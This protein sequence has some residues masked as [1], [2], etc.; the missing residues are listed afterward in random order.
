MEVLEDR[1]MFDGVPDGTLDPAALSHDDP[2]IDVADSRVDGERD[3]ASLQ[4]EPKGIVFVD[5]RVAGFERL[6]AN[7]ATD[8]NRE[9]VFLNKQI[10]TLS[11]I[12][13]VLADRNADDG[14]VYDTVQTV[15]AGNAD[16]PD[17]RL[18]TLDQASLLAAQTA[19]HLEGFDESSSVG[20]AAATVAAVRTEV[21]VIDSG[22]EDAETILAGLRDASDQVTDWIVVRIDPS[23]DGIQQISA[24]LAGQKSVDA[25]HLISHGDGRGIDLGGTHLDID[26]IAAFA[27]EVALWGNAFAEDA[28]ILI[29]GC[30][31]ASTEAGRS[32]VEAMAALTDADVA[33]SDDATGHE[34]LGGDWELEFETGLIGT[35]SLGQTWSFDVSWYGTLATINGTSGSDILEGTNSTDTISGKGGNDILLGGVDLIDEGNFNSSSTSTQL[36]VTTANSGWDVSSGSVDFLSASSGISLPNDPNDASLRAVDLNDGEISRLVG[37]LTIG[38]TY[39]VAFFMGA[40]GVM[41]QTLDVAAVGVDSASMSVTMPS[42]NNLSNIDWQVKL[43]TFT[44]TATSHSIQFTSTSGSPTAGAIIAGVRLVHDNAADGNDTIYGNAGDDL[45]IGGGGDNELWEDSGTNIIVS[46][47]GEDDIEGGDDNDTIYAGDG[48]NY[49]DGGSGDDIIMSG[50]GDDELY[51]GGDNDTID[52]GDGENI[53]VGDA[54][55]DNI[56]AGSGD[57]YIR[58]GDGNDVIDGGDGNNVIDGDTGN[59]Q[60]TSGS[61]NDEIWSTEGAD[62]IFAGAGDDEIYSYGDMAQDTIDGGEGADTYYIYVDDTADVFQDSGTDGAIDILYLYSGGSETYYIT[63]QF[64]KA[65]TGIDTIYNDWTGSTSYLGSSSHATALYWDFSGMELEAVEQVH[66]GTQNDTIILDS[67]GPDNPNAIYG[68]GGNDTLTDGAGVHSLYGGPGNDRLYGG[69]GNDR[70]FG[71]LGVDSARYDGAL[72]DYTINRDSYGLANDASVLR[73]HETTINGTDEENDF[74]YGTV[75]YLYFSD[76]TYDTATGGFVPNVLQVHSMPG[77]QEIAV[78]AGLTF[79]AANGNSISITDDSSDLLEVTLSVSEGTVTLGAIPAGLSFSSND[80]TNDATMTFTGTV[81]DINTALDG[82]QFTSPVDYE[83]GAVLS[84]ESSDLNFGTSDADSLL[85]KIGDALVVDTA[86]D[87]SNNGDTSSLEALYL[88]K[89]SDGLISLREAIIASNN[90]L[91]TQAIRF[92]ISGAGPH[93]IA[94]TSALPLISDGVFID[95]WSEPDYAADGVPVIVIDAGGV[96]SFDTGLE[97]SLG[98]DGSTVRGLVLSNISHHGIEIDSDNNWIYGNYI[99]VDASGLTAAAVG[100]AGVF[101]NAGASNNIIGTNGDAVADVSER[102]VIGAGRNGVFLAGDGVNSNTIAGNYIGVGVDGETVLGLEFHGVRI[103]GD[104]SNNTIGGATAALGNVIAGADDAAVEIGSESTTNSVLNNRIGISADGNTLL[105]D[106][107][108]GVSILNGADGTT[109]IGNSIGGS[110]QAGILIDGDSVG[111]VI[112]GNTIGTDATGTLNWGNGEQGILLAGGATGTVIGGVGA[113]EGNT[114]AF[115]GQADPDNGAGI[116]IWGTATG[117]TIQ[118]NSIYSNQG[119]GIDLGVASDDGADP[120]DAGDS[121]TGG[122]NKQNWGEAGGPSINDAGDFRYYVNLYSFAGGTTYTLDFYASSDRDGGQ[123]EGERYLFSRTGLTNLQSGWITETGIDAT[124]GEYITVTLTDDTTGDTSEFSSY[125]VVVDSDGS[126]SAPHDLTLV[127]AGDGGVEINADGGKDANLVVHSDGNTGSIGDRIGGL[128]SMT[129]EVDFAAA[130]G[131]HQTLLS[132]AASDPDDFTLQIDPDAGNGSVTVMINGSANQVV[133]SGI[134]Y[135]TL[136]DGHRHQLAF[137]WDNTDGDWSIYVDGQLAESGTGLAT[138]LTLAGDA[139]NGTLMFGQEQDAIGG[140]FNAFDTFRGTYFDAR[141][142]DSVRSAGQIAAGA[143]QTLAY[144]EPGMLANWTFNDLST[145]GVVTESVAGNSLKLEAAAASGFTS[146]ESVLSVWLDENAVNGTSVGKVYGTDIERE[147]L[148]AAFLA[149][150]PT[151]HYSEETDKFYKVLSGAYDRDAADAAA[152]GETLNANAGS[153]LTIESAHEN[154]LVRRWI[155]ETG[156]SRVWLSGSDLA[157]AD[158]WRW[159]D[160][161]L[162]FDDDGA[163]DGAYENFASGEPDGAVDPSIVYLSM[164]SDGQ[165]ADSAAAQ[166]STGVI[167]EWSADEA[168]DRSRMVLYSIQSQTTPG[169]FAIDSDSGVITVADASAIDYETLDSHQLNIRVSDNSGQ[170]YKELFTIQ[171]LDGREPVSLSGLEIGTLTYTENDPE[172]AITSTLEATAPEVVA[173]ESATIAISVGYANGQDVLTFDTTN[174]ITGDWDAATGTLTLTGS[175]T[176]AAYQTALRSVM[177]VNTSEVPDE[178][179]REV[180]FTV[181]DGELDSNTVHRS[182]AVASVNDAPTFPLGTG[183]LTMPDDAYQGSE[184]TAIL[185]QPDGKSLVVSPVFRPFDDS[186]GLNRYTESGVLD[187]SFGGGDGSVV[188]S[189]GTGYAYPTSASLQADGKIVVAGSFYDI[190]AGYSVA[191][192]ARYNIDGTLDTSFGTAG[193][194]TTVVAG[195]SSNITEVTVLADGKILGAGY[196]YDYDGLNEIALFQFNSDGTLDASFGAGNGYVTATGLADRSLANSMVVQSDGKILVAGIIGNGG[197]SDF[198]VARY[199]SDGTL[200]TSFDGDGVVNIVTGGTEAYVNELLLQPD[201]KILLVG[202]T[203]VNGDSDSVVVRLLADGSIDTSFGGGDGMGITAIAGSHETIYAAAIQ[204]DGKIVGVGGDY[205]PATFKNRGFT[206]RYNSDGTLDTSFGDDGIVPFTLGDTSSDASYGIAFDDDGKVL[207]AGSSYSTRGT[208]Y[209]VRYNTDGTLDMTY[210]A[211]HQLDGA[212]IFIENGSAVVLDDDVAIVDADLIEL[213]NFAGATLTLQRNVAAND[214]DL[215]S[216]TGTLSFAG[217]DLVVD[218]T[219]IGSVTNT[220]GTLLL[221]FNSNATHALVRAAMSQIAYANANDT[222]AASVQI[223]WM[224]DDGNTGDQGS[225]GALSTVGSTTVA[226]IA[227]NDAPVVSGIET[228]AIDYTENDGAVAISSTLAISDGD[229]TQIESA[230]VAISSGYAN[231][232]DLLGFVDQNGIMGAWD[233]GTGTLTLSGSAT[234]AEYQTALRSVTYTNSSESPNTATRTVSVTVNDGDENSATQNRDIAITAVNDRP[235]YGSIVLPTFT[236]HELTNNALGASFVTTADMDGDGDLDVLSASFV[237]DRII[238]FENDGS[239]IFTE[240]TVTS[241]ADGSLAVYVVDLDEDG[242]LDIVSASHLDDTV[243]WYENDGNENFT[244]HVI[245]TSA[246]FAASVTAADVDGDGDLDILSASYRDHKIVWYENDGN[247]NFTIR[248]ITSTAMG[249]RSVATADMDGD[250][251]LD[252]LSAARD[253]STVIW[254]ENDGSENFTTHVIAADAEGAMHVMTADVDGDGDLDVLSASYDDNSVT[255]Y[256]NDGSQNFTQHVVDTTAVGVISVAAADVDGDGDLDLLSASSVG[257]T[258]AWYENDGNQNFTQ[259]MIAVASDGAR[260]VIMADIDGDGDLDVVTASQYDNTVTWYESEVIALIGD[261]PTFVEDGPAVVL[262]SG[263][264]IEDMELTSL[265]DFDGASLSFARMGGPSPDDHF[266]ATG[267]LAFVGTTT[268]NIELSSVVIGTYTNTAGTLTLSFA[269]GTTNAQVNAAARAIAYSNSNNTPPTSVQ[270]DWTFDDGNT[271]SQGIGGAR[272]AI[273]RTTVTI[274]ATNDDPTNAGSLPSSISVIEDVSSNVDLSLIDLSDFDAGTS[275]LTVSLTT[276]TGGH[277]T[278]AAAAGITVGGTSTARTLTG[279]L[280]D[281]NSYLNTASNLTYLHGTADINGDAADTIQVDVTDNG[282]TGNGGGGTIDLG[283]VDVDIT[284]VNDDPTNAGSLPATITVTED[285]LSNVDLSAIDL[286]DVDHNGGDLTL[287]LT[288]STGGNLTAS[289]LGGVWIAGSGSSSLSLTGTLSMLNVYLNNASAIQYLSG[290]SHA[291]GIAADTLQL[292]FTDNGHSGIGGGLLIDFG[293]LD[294]DIASVND[295]PTFEIGDGVVTT[296]VGALNESASD[297]L[298]QPDGKIVVAGYVHNGLSFDFGLVRYNV[299]GTLDTSFGGGD[300]VVTTATGSQADIAYS[301][302]LQP[303]GKILL[304]GFTTVSGTYHHTVVRY[305]ID[306]TLDSSFG[307]GGIVVSN[308]GANGDAG[309]SVTLQSDGKI[310]VSGWKMSGG[311]TGSMLVRYHSDGTLDTS[312]GGGDGIVVSDFGAT[313][314]VYDDVVVQADGK[315]LVAG[316]LD[317][318]TAT[319]RDISLVRYNSDGTLD[320]SFG[321]AGIVST[322]LGDSTDNASRIVLTAD[323][324]ILLSGYSKHAGDFDFTVLRYNSDGTLDFSFGGGLGVVTTDVQAD[325]NYANGLIMQDDGKFLVAGH[326]ASGPEFVVVRYHSDGTLDTSFGDDGIAVGAVN[327]GIVG[328]NNATLQADGKILLTGYHTQSANS[329]FLLVRYNSD[330]TLDTRFGIDSSSLAGTVSYTEDGPAVVLDINVELSDQELDAL[331]G[332]DGNYAGAQITLVRDGGAASEDVLDFANGNGITLVGDQLIKNGQSIATFDTTTTAGALVITFTDGNGEIPT[333]SDVVQMLRQL[334]YANSNDTPPASVQIHWTFNDG[335]TGSQGSGGALDTTGSTLVTITAVDDAPVIA[336]IESIAIDYIENDGAVAISPSLTI[337][338]VDDTHIVSAVVAIGAG[339]ANGQDELSFVNQNGIS[340]NWNASTGTLVLSGTATLAQYQTTLR[341]VTYANSSEVPD[342]TTRTI[343]FT[344]HDGQSNSNVVAR[345]ITITSVN[346]GPVFFEPTLDSA[347]LSFVHVELDGYN[348]IYLESIVLQSDGKSLLLGTAA[349]GGVYELALVRYTASGISDTSFG[350][351]DGSTVTSFGSDSVYAASVALQADGKILVA[352]N[353]YHDDSSSIMLVRYNSDGTLDSSFG[354]GDGITTT[355]VS[356]SYDYVEEIT[357]QDD[358]KILVVGRITNGAN[359][360]FGAIRYNSDGSLDASFGGG[361]GIVED[362]LGGTV[363]N[364][365][366]IIVQSDGKILIAGGSSAGLEY[367]VVVARLNSD[368]SWDSGFDGDGILKFDLGGIDSSASSVVLQSD[369]RIVVAGYISTS[370]NSDSDSFVVRLLAD[371]T[372]DTSFSDDGIVITDVDGAD[373]YVG[374]ATVQGDGKIVVLSTSYGSTTHGQIIRYNVD[375]TIDSS[376]GDDGVVNIA[377]GE[378]SEDYS[379]HLVIDADGKM[380][381]VGNSYSDDVIGFVQRLNSDGTLD[382]T[383]GVEDPLAG[384]PS[385]VEGGAAFVL[386]D[387]VSIFDEELVVDDNFADSTLTLLRSGGANA[388]DQFIATGTLSFSGG[389]LV[390]NGITIGSVTNDAGTLAMVFNGNVTQALLSSAMQQIAYAN[391]SDTPP[392][393]VQI[394]WTFDDGNTGAQGIVGALTA[395]QS[396]I[397]AITAVNDEQVLAVNTGATVVEG[398][399]AN[400]ITS[401]M[402]QTTDVDNTN[403][404]LVYVVDTLPSNGTL[405]RDSVAMSASDTFSQ[406][407][408]AAGLITYDHD[409]SQTTSDSFAFTVDDGAGTTSSSSFH[410]TIT[411]VNDAPYDLT[412]TPLSVAENSAN[413]TSVGT[414]TGYDVDSASLTYSIFAQDFPGAFAIDSVTGEITVAD[415]RLLN[416]ED[417]TSQGVTVR[418]TDASGATYDEEMTVTITDEAGDVVATADAITVVAGAPIVIDPRGND[419][420]GSGD[421]LVVT[422]IIDA[423]AGDAVTQLSSPGDTATLASGTTLTLR[424]DGRLTVVAAADGIET[425]AYRVSD[426]TTDDLELVTLT[427]D[428]NELAAQSIGLVTTWDTTQAGSASDTITIAAAPGS[429]NYTV[430]WGDGTSTVGASGDLSHTY[431]SPGQYTVTIVGDFAGFNFDGGGDAAKILSVEQWGNVAFEDLDDAFDGAVNLQINAADA[432]DL[433]GV[434]SLKEMFNGAT[435]MNADLSGW[436]VASVDN[437][438]G[439]FRGAGSFNQDLSGWDVSNVTNMASMFYGASSFNEDVSSWDVSSVTSMVGMFQDAGSFNQDVNGWDVSNVTSMVR[440][441]Y[442]AGT[443]NQDVSGWDVS[444]VTSMINMFYSASSFNQDINDWD[445]SNVTSTAIMFYGASSFNG[446]VSGWDVSSV[447]NMVGMFQDAVSFDQDVSGWDVSNVTN[448]GRMFSGA[449]SFNQDISGWDVSNVTSMINM[450]YNAGSFNQDVSRWDVSNVTGM[451]S[452]FSGASSFNQD[453]SGWDVSNVTGMASMFSGAGSFNQD[454]SEW[455][456]SGVTSMESMFQD[457]SAF[458]QNLG[459]WD[460]SSL[461]V[462]TSMLSNSDLSIPNYDATL[463]GWASQTVKP[464]VPLGADGLQYSI[465]AQAARDLLINDHNWSITGDSFYNYVPEITSDGGADTASVHV[466]EDTA[467]VTTVAASDQDGLLNTLSYSIYGGSDAARFAIDS[468]TGELAFLS[469][470]D[471]ENPTDVGGDNL[472]N[473]V[474]RVSDDQGGTDDQTLTV[475]VSSINDAPLA[476]NDPSFVTD[477]ATA[478]TGLDILANDIDVDVDL[479]TISRID[480]NAFTVGVPISLASGTLV[481]VNPDGT[482]DFDPANVYTQLGDIHSAI[483][484]FTYEIADGQGAFDTATVTIQIQG[485]DNPISI[486]ELTDGPTIDTD[487]EVFESDLPQ[488]T[489]AVGVGESTS[490]TF[491]LQ[492]GDGLVSL[493][494]D[495]RVITA[496][497]LID[498]AT[499]PVFVNTSLGRLEVSGY[500]AISGVVSYSYTLT[501]SGDH[502]AGSVIDNIALTITDTDG[503][504]VNATLGILIHDDLPSTSDDANSVLEDNGTAATGNVLGN[505]QV[506]ADQTAKLVA[507]VGSGANLPSAIHLGQAL[508]GTYGTIAMQADGSYSYL[509]D[510]LD[511]AVS[512]LSTGESLTDQF[513]YEVVDADGS[514]STATLTIQINGTNDSPNLSSDS[515]ATFESTAT[516]FDLLANDSDDEGHALSITQIDGQPILVGGQVAVAGGSVTL[517]ADGTV[518]FVPTAGFS[519]SFAFEYAVEDAL[520]GSETAAVQV[521]VVPSDSRP[522]VTLD[523]TPLTINDPFD[524]PTPLVDLPLAQWTHDSGTVAPDLQDP[525]LVAAAANE[526][527]HGGLNIAIGGGSASIQ[528]VDAAT[529]ANAIADEDY[530]AYS[531]TV[532]DPLPQDHHLLLTG[533]EMF[534]PTGGPDYLRTVVVSRDPDFATAT[535]IVANDLVSGDGVAIDRDLATAISVVAGETLYFR[536][537]LYDSSGGDVVQYDNFQAKFTVLDANDSVAFSEGDPAVAVDAGG[538]ADASD[539]GDADLVQ[540][541]INLSGIVDANA[542]WV[543]IAGQTVDLSSSGNWTGLGVGGSVVDLGYNQ[544]TQSFTITNYSGAGDAIPQ[545]D[546]DLLIRGLQYENTSQNPSYG[547]RTFEFVLTDAS[548]LASAPVMSN[549]LVASVNDLPIAVNDSFAIDQDTPL[550]GHLLADNG[551]GVD[552]DPD[553]DTLTVTQINGQAFASGH[554]FALPS[555]ATIQMFS[556]GTFRFDPGTAFDHLGSGEQVTDSFSYQ[557]SDFHGGFATATVTIQIDG[558]DDPLSID[559]IDDGI[560]SGTDA[561][562]DESHLATGSAAMPGGATTSGSFVLQVGDQIESLQVAGVSITTAQLLNA[563]TVPVVIATTHGQ[564]TIDSYDSTSGQVD[565]RYELTSA[566]DHSGGTATESIGLIARDLDGDQT[567][568]TLVI[569]IVDDL[570]IANDDWDEV[571]NVAGNPSSVADGNVVTGQGSGSDP[572]FSDGVV[573]RVGADQVSAPVTGV[574]AGTGSPDNTSGNLGLP[575][576]GAFGS[577]V[578][579]ADGAYMYTPD[580]A[581]A[582]VAALGPDESLTDVFTYQITDADGSQ[583]TATITFTILGTP[584]IIGTQD[585]GLVTG[586]DASVKEADL[587]TGSTA[588]PAGAT[589]SGSFLVIAPRGL[590]QLK[591]AGTAISANQLDWVGGAPIMV[592]TPHGSIQILSYDQAT[593]LVEYKFTL[594]SPIDHANG[595]GSESITLAVKDTFGDEVQK[596]MLIAIVDDAPVAHDDLEYDNG[597]PGV[598][599]TGNVT[600]NDIYGANGPAAD[601]IRSV[602]VGSSDPNGFEHQVGSPINGL[603]GWLTLSADG[604]FAYQADPARSAFQ[605][606]GD[607]QTANDLFTYQIADADGSTSNAELIVVVSGLNEAPTAEGTIEP[608]TAY[609]GQTIVPLDIRGYFGD[610][611]ATDVLTYADNG[612]LPTGLSLDSATGIISGTPSGDASQTG[613]YAVQITA[614]DAE[615]LTATQSFTW[616]VHNVAPVA[617]EHTGTV[618]ESNVYIGQLLVGNGSD[619]DPDGDTPLQVVAVNGDPAAVGIAVTLQSGAIVQIHADGSYQYDPNGQFDNL[620]VGQSAL[621]QFAYTISDG[622]GGTDTGQV[623]VTIHGENEPP[624]VGD[625]QIKVGANVSTV[626]PVLQNAY[627]PNGDPLTVIVL[628]QPDNASVAVHPNGTLTFTPNANFVGETSFRYLVEDPYG[629]TASATLEVEV[630]APFAFDSLNDFSKGFGQRDRVSVGTGSEDRSPLSMQIFALAAEPIVSGHANYGSQIVG[631]IYDSSGRLIGERTTVADIGGNW[632]MQFQGVSNFEHYRIEIEQ[633]DASGTAIPGFGL[634]HSNSTYQTLQPLTHVRETLTVERV[635]REMPSKAIQ[636]GHGTLNNPLGLGI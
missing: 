451:A 207:V 379:S 368:G 575:V 367:S 144:S 364:I 620:G 173:I 316:Y 128:G 524:G 276:S 164:G 544:Y 261:N 54:G 430:Y 328:I 455:D 12:A 227:V 194:V 182:I 80:G 437:M 611:D 27:G 104:A 529:L 118:G 550:D 7:L 630:R 413:G 148:I 292:S 632:T 347:D 635:M 282:N 45:I 464:N 454:V 562:V 606:L 610:R 573:D 408:I 170:N 82:L 50:S 520:G 470:P 343:S 588:D 264:E 291:N 633:N 26:S 200:D 346:D 399:T 222:P 245:T 305:N 616:N 407:D 63:D 174:G 153:L 542:E 356:G 547:Q 533:I 279:N 563:Q 469:A 622:Q 98:S 459:D 168:L 256:E 536:V 260:S 410:W 67:A 404:E 418:V 155:S 594:T 199:N 480:G 600:D 545:S 554:V 139:A 570:A 22:V 61:G 433:S 397:V 250:G 465:A 514:R 636:Q 36:D 275:S 156:E 137:T 442:G 272:Q 193:M 149:A 44:A 230:T 378:D 352:A 540:L 531:V 220:G 302:T 30:D 624:Q 384:S 35:A 450:F 280:A 592:A 246:D 184:T 58:G 395:T 460:I 65:E 192:L 509:L 424:S 507:T 578:L 285:V 597:S 52:A 516:R 31:L 350:G 586:T 108:F 438:N 615:G 337:S 493:Q 113:G 32:L 359:N 198:A 111:S 522:E 360:D 571:I 541:S 76:G 322:D 180:R 163:V 109:I 627:D 311:T 49:V 587:S 73:V 125:S 217:G 273:G 293:T 584:T 101:L 298:E 25:L 235:T 295:A 312:F 417:A 48:N 535:T 385:Y 473:V 42:G 528:G 546:L 117:N 10:D 40:D 68:N 140:G 581:N 262:G 310:L 484:S 344:I 116:A 190:D 467:A 318:G 195:F 422:E 490:G 363:S 421:P 585:E 29:Y 221:A 89:G 492:P 28:D 393:S 549:I 489:D 576:A 47:A 553:G 572:N 505:D 400:T 294:V 564:L 102:N 115:S 391:A 240:H 110:V 376:F 237:D 500:N 107:T 41:T 33:A 521:A 411:P 466:N 440:M 131:A 201:G 69:A 143:G 175:A 383:Y 90:T 543:T 214:D 551:G 340:G 628:T 357:L 219:T 145:D 619:Y 530:L 191:A 141:V 18:V 133:A 614:T 13:D 355:N 268:G 8:A 612:S 511:P 335:N 99:G 66:G 151:L 479:L 381:V 255:W 604:G 46:G 206:V 176:L 263:V 513:T 446:N 401:A 21:V 134:D 57:D 568:V 84:M 333:S 244:L 51:G 601:P 1:V 239:G 607:G 229:G 608:Q 374:S 234:I 488:G 434:T 15:A 236:A 382:S 403:E 4:A 142:F 582:Q 323:G 197:D 209:L 185:L 179:T 503:D 375:G 138:G 218:G 23:D 380:I 203:D 225:G 72:A 498:T 339:Y 92:D 79:N 186:F 566:A 314:S 387:H 487:G 62:T 370:G 303:D 91:G 468:V 129:I 38:E 254:Y 277:L 537:Y 552:S 259:H 106:N 278:A 495:S 326:V 617:V 621:D 9:I 88:D 171:L 196:V 205:D 486:S 405:Y 392:A 471:Y 508:S 523:Q 83:G 119:I 429:S 428:S 394:D 159:D 308:I 613:P 398:A 317:S 595:Q 475:A 160:G 265:D 603:F 313:S 515:F 345:D 242:D 43:F 449:S 81:A 20:N 59:D 208:G 85:I 539:G 224:F 436:D 557:I 526:T 444:S 165:W 97:L 248:V 77:T 366:S 353:Q 53:V 127:A 409:D 253:D 238:W 78:A 443:F 301:A 625:S 286:S 478:L 123:V 331:N 112:Q 431:A 386:D 402:L 485:L 178:T 228:E 189:F 412:S 188:T 618:H 166:A 319:K 6:V 5:K 517:H 289:T 270:I 461:A 579:Q 2:L 457:A 499:T 358:G 580:Y 39:H 114:I 154:E 441:F 456:V 458:N 502:A 634:K 223:D 512:A 34:S 274:T 518:T 577:L 181:N 631:R 158:Q 169:A 297:I 233:V 494:I 147:A 152:S 105:G 532:A 569:Y 432:P 16:D 162:F 306:G 204:A 177:Y 482:I 599:L 623:V 290:V 100:G 309:K 565:Y 491:L 122:N 501:G 327:G 281:L 324:K 349:S 332:G 103:V 330:G 121:D 354:G 296:P 396:T 527:S 415:G 560:H 135:N 95:G 389:D 342:T 257:D 130:D 243:S 325:D 390:V 426:G 75:E 146:S 249:A 506:G 425:F 361:D 419:V 60:L 555:G 17:P 226:I 315:I 348:R 94:L 266:S 19:R 496:A 150:Y 369:G 211:D 377:V 269:A 329:D 213:D 445:V 187:T 598:P 414:V 307:V 351:G 71:G 605:E 93:T 210:G 362:S 472:Y 161:T 556:D 596:T 497:E 462:A 483:E 167:V 287:T 481:T 602:V 300:G 321:V 372:F 559:G 567:A 183:F 591:V 609:D 416:Y 271:G 510:D 626:I 86:S 504:I 258:V 126:G 427:V 251:D 548:G 87:S 283:S 338:D 453:V 267:N 70:L 288:T 448:M 252:V 452:M 215:F 136:L 589:A 561:S 202:D 590:V 241:T 336:A 474:V 216:A 583:S 299:D 373:E 558:I 420:S 11:Q 341:S 132:Y 124:P 56:Q 477:E 55:D 463:I 232:Q 304:T 423:A 435:A 388:E 406:A 231:G 157:E 320:N 212:P 574:V 284:P 96:G 439:L 525:T 534:K 247:E 334:T 629:G 538:N 172:L 476:V 37:G 3:G 447:T 519:G 64:S 593:G 371:G 74:V 365:S 120:N 24:A 14:T